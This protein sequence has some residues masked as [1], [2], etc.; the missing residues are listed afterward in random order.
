MLYF[1][2]MKAE[3]TSDSRSID[4]CVPHRETATVPVALLC[5]PRNRSASALCIQHSAFLAG[6]SPYRLVTPSNSQKNKKNSRKT[7]NHLSRQHRPP[8]SVIRHL[9]S[10]LRPLTSALLRTSCP[11]HFSRVV[12]SGAKICATPTAT[13]AVF[14]TCLHQLAPTSGKKGVNE[15]FSRFAQLSRPPL[16][17]SVFRVFR[18][19][20]SERPADSRISGGRGQ[21]SDLF[22]PIQSY[23]DLF[24][25]QQPFHLRPLTSALRPP[26]SVL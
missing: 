5:V 16:R 15:K 19:F 17:L 10:V 7:V 26:S 9:S 1:G 23:S 3:L 8:S 6:N 21:F 18:V 20:A 12:R 11:S 25:L 4:L 2:R 22:R 13:P 24:L 14:C